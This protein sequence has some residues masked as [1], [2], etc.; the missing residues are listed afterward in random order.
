MLLFPVFFFRNRL[1]LVVCNVKQRNSYFAEHNCGLA[2][3][4]F[5]CFEHKDGRVT[6]RSLSML[7]HKNIMSVALF[8]RHTATRVEDN[9]SVKKKISILVQSFRLI[10]WQT[11]QL[12]SCNPETSYSQYIT[13]KILKNVINVLR[14][15][16]LNFC[17]HDW[18]IQ[19]LNEKISSASDSVVF[20]V[21]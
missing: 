16:K 10:W 7:V 15:I 20:M 4:G 21:S 17:V 14:V 5:R 19:V 18:S 12:T 11:R 1:D 2:G 6:P 9:L 13:T 8:M 3:F